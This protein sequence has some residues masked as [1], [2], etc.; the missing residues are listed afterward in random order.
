MRAISCIT[1]VLFGGPRSNVAIYNGHISSG[2]TN[3]TAGVF[4][5]A[6]F[7]YGI[8][9]SG[10]SNVRVRDVSVAGV[11]FQGI[12][13]GL[14]SSTVVEACA[15]NVAGSFGIVAA[16]VS[17]STAVNTTSTSRASNAAAS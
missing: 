13:L 10:L 4:S 3:T 7:S 5:G 2:V 11:L 14:S 16:S 9:G 12:N 1:V 15:V 6:G 8:T 17:D